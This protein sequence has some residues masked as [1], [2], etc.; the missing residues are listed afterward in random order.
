MRNFFVAPTLITCL[1]N[2]KSK[3]FLTVTN[4]IFSCLVELVTTVAVKENNQAKVNGVEQTYRHSDT[5]V[6]YHSVS[7]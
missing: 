5:K 2:V 6:D 7:Y 1:L 4:R 3:L